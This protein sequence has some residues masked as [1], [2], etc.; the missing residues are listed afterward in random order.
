MQTPVTL[1]SGRSCFYNMG[2]FIDALPNGAAYLWHTG[3]VSGFRCCHY[4]ALAGG[5]TA[6]MFLNVDGDAIGSIGFD[7]IEAVAP[8]TTPAW[9]PAIAERRPD[10]QRTLRRLYTREQRSEQRRV[11]DEEARP[12]RHMGSGYLIKK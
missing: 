4:H 5:V 10:R 3:S 6:M 7:L 12:G 2:W 1:T 8:G 9:L 11:G